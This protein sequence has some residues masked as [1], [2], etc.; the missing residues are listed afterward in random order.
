[1]LI[2]V[3]HILLIMES[4]QLCE[5]LFN[6]EFSCKCPMF[7]AQMAIKYINGYDVCKWQ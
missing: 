1:M 3:H 4:Q 2:I 6:K 7:M 5:R